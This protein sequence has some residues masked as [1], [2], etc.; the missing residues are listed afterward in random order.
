L[1]DG[2]A[3]VL[4]HYQRLAALDPAFYLEH[5]S[6]LLRGSG[7]DAADPLARTSQLLRR[8]RAGASEGVEAMAFLL[9][10][11]IPAVLEAA[12]AHD[13]ALLAQP[14]FAQELHRAVAAYVLP[15]AI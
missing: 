8:A 2:L 10:R 3:I 12:L 1:R 4:D 7:A 15:H 11:G 5:K 9:A 6:E 13:P 14:D